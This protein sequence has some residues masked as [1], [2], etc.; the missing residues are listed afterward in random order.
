[1]SSPEYRVKL[2]PKAEQDIENI[3]RYTGE[4]WGEN[5]I[6][7]YRDKI[8]DALEMIRSNPTI[9]HQSRA[10]P[11]THRIYHF[12]SHVMVYR[13][14]E[15]EI[16]VVRMLHQRMDL[17][18]HI[19]RKG[20]PSTRNGQLGKAS[21]DT[22]RVNICY[23]P[24]RICWAICAGD[25]GAFREAVKFSHTMWGGRFNPIAIVDRLEEAE[26]IVEVFRADMIVPIGAGDALAG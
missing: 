1:M 19:Q 22:V 26:R 7:V 12:G 16:G 13:I 17:S 21:K 23:R 18:L 25:R 20:E 10:L 3:L 9:G 4:T 11:E 5:Q 6:T 2:S 24:L 14:K 15:T 8:I